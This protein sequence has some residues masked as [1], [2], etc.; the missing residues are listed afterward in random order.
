MPKSSS[1]FGEV[2]SEVDRLK[3]LEDDLVESTG[4]DVA[5]TF[6]AGEERLG[7]G[8]AGPPSTGSDIAVHSPQAEVDSGR[9]VVPG[10]SVESLE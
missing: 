1:P 3:T 2:D 8:A 7:A 4:S 10:L 5:W 6:S 9:S